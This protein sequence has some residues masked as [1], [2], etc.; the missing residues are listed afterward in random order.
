MGRGKKKA[1]SHKLVPPPPPSHKLCIYCQVHK[2]AQTFAQHRKACKRIWEMDHEASG[3]NKTLGN[4][5]DKGHT[6]SGRNVILD[7]MVN[8]SK[9]IIPRRLCIDSRYLDR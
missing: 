1:S 9:S 8:I 7:E 2:P 3:V 4:D 5:S 6:A